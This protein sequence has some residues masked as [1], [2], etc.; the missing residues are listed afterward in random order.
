MAENRIRISEGIARAKNQGIEIKPI[1]LAKAIFPDSK[2]DRSAYVCLNNYKNGIYTKM[3]RIQIVAL[4]KSL[5]VD[6]NYLFGI[7]PVNQ[8]KK[9]NGKTNDLQK[10]P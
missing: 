1:E 5:R 2:T 10:N 9:E 7:K 3:D 8:N 4:C 6:A